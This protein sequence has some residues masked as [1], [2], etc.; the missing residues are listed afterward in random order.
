MKIAESNSRNEDEYWSLMI[1]WVL[2]PYDHYKYF[3]DTDLTL[4]ALTFLIF[5]I[6]THHSLLRSLQMA[7]LY[8]ML[9]SRQITSKIP[10]VQHLA[11]N[12]SN[13]RIALGMALLA[14]IILIRHQPHRVIILWLIPKGL[15]RQSVPNT[16]LTSLAV[17]LR[18][19]MW[20]TII[21]FV[22]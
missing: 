6:H 17:S 14:W 12:L 18:V 22:F 2:R 16:H 19:Y 21:I 20:V 7:Q 15:S 8:W 4:L 11:K 9:F 1:H 5:I 10:Q 3:C 13:K